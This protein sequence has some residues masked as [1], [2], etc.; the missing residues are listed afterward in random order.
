MRWQKPARLAI[1]VF[2]VAFAVVVGVIL[3]RGKQAPTVQEAIN[4]Q[5]P[6]A[7]SE[8]RGGGHF[9]RAEPGKAPFSLKWGGTHLAFSDGRQ[10]FNGGIELRAQSKGKSFTATS[11]EA[12]LL[13]K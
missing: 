12:D 4:R 5:D 3:R 13:V 11:R 10:K 9:Q 8:A 6:Q 7:V 2:V 1:A